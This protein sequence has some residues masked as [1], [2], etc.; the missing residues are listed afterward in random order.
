MLNYSMGM[1]SARVRWYKTLRIKK[2]SFFYKQIFRAKEIEGSL[3][4]K[5]DLKRYTSQKKKI[6]IS[7]S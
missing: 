6:Y 1:Q 7:Q 5:R 4:M 3:L 2:H